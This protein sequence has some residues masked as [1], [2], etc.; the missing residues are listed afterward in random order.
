LFNRVPKYQKI[1]QKTF[2]YICNDC[3]EFS[4]NQYEFCEKCGAK[5]SV[6]KAMIEDYTKYYLKEEKEKSRSERILS[7]DQPENIKLLALL[8]TFFLIFLT[9]E[10]P[11]LINNLLIQ[12][13]PN[14]N[15]VFNP[16]EI[17]VF[18]NGVRPIGYICL[19]IIVIFI[20]LGFLIKK[21]KISVSS[22]FLLFLPTF[23]SFASYMFF[24]AGIGILEV[25]WLPLDTPY[26]NFLTL[27]I[28]V[29]PVYLL[30][31][32]FYLGPIG[33]IVLYIFMFL[34]WIFMI[35]GLYIFTSGVVS[36]FYGKYQKR[37]II[38]FSIYK[39]SRHPQ[40]LG[41]L[42][43]S[44]GLFVQYMISEYIIMPMG[45]IGLKASLPWVIF[46]LIIVGIAFLEDINLL[47]K[48]PDKYAEYRKRTPFLIKLPKTLNL[49]ASFP[50][51]Y[52]LKK[53]F[54]ET[55]KD[56]IKVVIFY[57]MI[58]IILSLLI[59]LMFPTFYQ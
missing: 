24:L 18:I 6:R 15:P 4:Y 48:Y 14:I 26:F 22:S 27:G 34:P 25:I 2:Q 36:W 39:Y 33:Y 31:F 59:L 53:S 49:I 7:D 23:G 46:A 40:Y 51:R 32:L 30:V 45:K 44:Y 17:E 11:F 43:W 29:F 12:I 28:I 5:N 3:G 13:F 52:I 9:F 10:I 56:I 1:F 57:G 35:L 54:P 42:I 41:F 38:E 16:D 20:I 8:F 21:E 50:L 37:D 19:I 58:I 55:N 47:K